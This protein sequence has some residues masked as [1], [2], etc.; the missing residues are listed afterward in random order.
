MSHAVT[1]EIGRTR[2]GRRKL[3]GSK[4]GPR[5]IGESWL[6]G[7][8]GSRQ[9]SAETEGVRQPQDGMK[10]VRRFQAWTEGAL[11]GSKAVIKKKFTAPGWEGGS[12]AAQD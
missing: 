12:S 3:G 6:G 11:G 2:L 1:K 9:L 7:T 8:E 5:D 4:L 10:E